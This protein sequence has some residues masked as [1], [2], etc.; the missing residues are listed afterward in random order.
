MILTDSWDVILLKVLS[1]AEIPAVFPSYLMEDNLQML[2]D[3]FHILYMNF[4]QKE[5][6]NM[7][8]IVSAEESITFQSG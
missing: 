8:S 5:L 4:V 6:I 3:T 7:R 2:R 1:N